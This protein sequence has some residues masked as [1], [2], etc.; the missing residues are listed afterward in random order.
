MTKSMQVVVT[1]Q[2][3]VRLWP[4]QRSWYRLLDWWRPRWY[5]FT[6]SRWGYVVGLT[7]WA[8]GRAALLLI[9]VT[10]VF[11]TLFMFMLLRFAF[12][13]GKRR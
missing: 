8:L 1:Q 6:R 12:T 13:G 5:R 2:K 11:G 4:G 9:K 7:L 3:P 10:V